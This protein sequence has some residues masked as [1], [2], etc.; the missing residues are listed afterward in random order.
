[1][2][3]P[4]KKKNIVSS[5]TEKQECQ[6]FKKYWETPDAQHLENLELIGRYKPSCQGEALIPVGIQAVEC[7]C[8]LGKSGPRQASN[9]KRAPWEGIFGPLTIQNGIIL[10]CDLLYLFNNV[11]QISSH[12]CIS[13]FNSFLL[14]H[15]INIA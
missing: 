15:Y 9:P 7:P 13:R 4:E 3:L 12:I 6:L 14:L 5:N 10:F 2:A 1:M 11:S 8:S